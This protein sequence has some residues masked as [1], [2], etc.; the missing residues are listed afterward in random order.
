MTTA[1]FNHYFFNL[2]IRYLHELTQTRQNRILYLDFSRR[3][4]KDFSAKIILIYVSAGNK[5]ALF[6]DDHTLPVALYL[7][8]ISKN[9][10]VIRIEAGNDALLHDLRLVAKGKQPVIPEENLKNSLARKEFNLLDKILRGKSIV[11]IARE[12]LES[13]K[14]I[15]SRVK[16]ITRKMKIKKITMLII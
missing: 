4:F 3:G 2:G 7:R 9:I 12:N 8:E 11:S 16:S 15:Y 10:F 13:S 14:T 5:V 6:C 1:P